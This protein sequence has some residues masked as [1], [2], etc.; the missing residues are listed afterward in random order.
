MP[1]RR[2]EVL[3]RKP[4]TW[5]SYAAAIF[6]T[7]RYS[8]RGVAEPMGE[9]CRRA[10]PTRLLVDIAVM[11]HCLSRRDSARREM[12]HVDDQCWHH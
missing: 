9:A 4:L 5:R 8:I 10:A 6:H 12:F 7:N 2:A 3:S 11:R 1:R